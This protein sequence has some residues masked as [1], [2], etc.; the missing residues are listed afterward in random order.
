MRE[1][2]LAYDDECMSCVDISERVRRLAGD[3]VAV[4]PLSS[5]RVTL[6]REQALGVDAP[7][8]PT[9]V[10][11]DGNSVRAWTGFGLSARLSLVLGLRRSLAVV[12]GLRRSKALEPVCGQRRRLLQAIPAATV[13]AF[14]LTG[15]LATPARAAKLDERNK[16]AKWIAANRDSL[17]HGYDEFVARPM[18]Y[19]RAIYGELPPAT[20]TQLWQEHLKRYRQSHPDLT[21]QQRSALDA[22]DDA[23]KSGQ[24]DVAKA[25]AASDTIEKAFGRDEAASI[26]A[27]LGEPEKPGPDTATSP[28]SPECWS[29]RECHCSVSDSWCSHPE[30][31]GCKNG[32]P[33]PTSRGCGDLWL[34][35]CD[36]TCS[37]L[38]N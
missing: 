27:T 32:C 11:V 8:L 24:I 20:Q 33:N 36:G 12:R 16:I 6:L 28:D 9:L 26:V 38:W 3:R 10:K 37:R 15:G 22:A 7:W 29:S 25:R 17:P 30:K 34:S 35:P 4:L 13:G 1:W 14:L 18:P 21:P 2:I 19:R 5:D 23:L 31:C